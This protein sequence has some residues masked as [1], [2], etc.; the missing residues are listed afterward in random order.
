MFLVLLF[1]LFFI[2]IVV[3]LAIYAVCEAWSLWAKNKYRL[4]FRL[5]TFLIILTAACATAGLVKPM[6][7]SG[8]W[9]AGIVLALIYYIFMV[10]AAFFADML[11]R[12]L[13]QLATGQR[14]NS[15]KAY[16]GEMAERLE[17]DDEGQPIIPESTRP[18]RKR[19]RRQPK[20]STIVLK[21]G[22]LRVRY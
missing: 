13:Y 17:L 2:A 15:M 3:W 8:E 12:D 14:G 10:G 19:E 9:G 4:R 22:Q 5:H 11:V 6:L 1:T 16:R 21:N 20:I 18:K 7:S